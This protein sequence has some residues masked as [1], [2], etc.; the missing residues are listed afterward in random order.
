[1]AAVQ[2]EER[3]GRVRRS[4]KEYLPILGWLPSYRKKWFVV[5]AVAAI[6][7]WALLVPQS[8]GYATLAGVPVQY[9]LY[10]AFAALVAYAIFGTSKQVVQG[11][12]GS[13]AA[14]SAAVVAPLVGT[15]AIGTD[16]AVPMT[17]ALAITTGVVYLALGIVKMGWISNFLSRAVMS[18]FVLGF[19]IGIIVDQSYKLLGVEK[20][21][22]S[23][24][25]ELV[26]TIRQIPDTN[27][28]TF[29]VGASAL[30][31]LLS[32][33]HF[34]PRWPRAL[35]VVALSIVAV[36]VF[37][38][39]SEGVAVTGD[40][41]T[42]L[43]SLGVPQG[44]WGDL[45]ALIAGALSIIF[46]GYSETLAGGRA[47]ASKHGDRL[48][49]N[50][51]LVAEGFACGAAGLVGGF[52]N[53]GSLSKTSVADAAGQKSQ[54]ASLINAVFVLLTILFLA[55]LFKNLPA[56][57][58]GAVVIDAMV[59]LIDLRPMARYFRVSRSDWICYMAAGLGILFFSIIQGIVIGVVLSLLLLIA[60]ASRPALRHMGKDPRSDTYLD[61]ARHESAIV[62]PGV[63][64]VRL[65]GPL[66]FADANLFHDGV[67]HLISTAD[68]PVHA[69]VLDME[70][71]AHT[72][73]DGAD[74]LAS[75]ASEMSA[76]GI[77]FG[78]AR[79][80]EAILDQWDRGGAIDAIGRD[81]VFASVRDAADRAVQ[82][83]E[84]IAS[85]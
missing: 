24:W 81:S 11:P 44:V 17:A 80:E 57:V 55:S 76:K 49:T 9:G 47:M 22:G 32:M 12:S 7:V 41:P 75:M 68:A 4:V 51:E 72:D 69:V 30:I 6:S 2:Q 38:L 15:A 23:Y 60:H 10:T 52:V 3:G 29:V 82:V 74:M 42:G 43:F 36:N 71:V 26:G 64:V 63:L 37:D 61:T 50:Q 70:A 28:Y 34:V 5:D 79:A 46:V 62:E 78:I 33:R 83:R 25:D 21:S 85:P 20:T 56:A 84:R 31:V 16:D 19:S 14:V 59:G 40:I 48:D 53:D 13:V 8:L 77:W 54:M 73:T 39:T 58:L 18:G 27:L 1:M 35:I 45:G 66:F 65:D 67:N